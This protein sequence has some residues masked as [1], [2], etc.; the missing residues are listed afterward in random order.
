MN[1]PQ[2]QLQFDMPTPGERMSSGEFIALVASLMALS[3][4]SVDIML[5]ALPQM[6]DALALSH[7]NDRQAIIFIYVLGFAAGQLVFG[8]LSDLYGRRPTV[9]VGMV[10]FIAG[11]VYAALA[12]D[13]TSMLAARAVQGI[14]AAAA[15]VIAVALV[16]DRYVGRQMARAMSFAMAVFFSVPVLAPAIGQALLQFGSWRLIFDVLIATGL[17]LGLWCLRLPGAAARVAAAP[18]SF[19][20]ALCRA[21]G[22]PTTIAYAVAAGL[23]LGCVLA[24]VSSAQQVFVDVFGLGAM[25]PLAFAAIATMIVGAAIANGFLIERLGMRRLSHASLAAFVVAAAVLLAEVALGWASFEVFVATMMPLF[26]LFGFVAPNFNALAMEPQGDNAGM[27]ASVVGSVS[28]G[29]GA[30]AGGVVGHLFDGTLLPLAAGLLA[31]SLLAF[32]VV[33]WAEGVRGMFRSPAPSSVRPPMPQLPVVSKFA[34]ADVAMQLQAIVEAAAPDAQLS[35][36]SLRRARTPQTQVAHAARAPQANFGFLNPPVFRGSTVLF[37]TA[38]KFL[39]GDQAYTYGRKSTPTVRALEQAIA[40][41]EGGEACVLTGSGYQAVSTAIMAFVKSGDHVLMADTVYQPT[42]AFCD[43]TLAKF[44][45]STTYYDPLIGE[46]IGQ[47]V[48][49]N[50]RLIYAESPG[51]QTFEVQ[52]IPS[53]ARVAA[54]RNLWLLMDNTWASPLYFKPFEHGVDVSIQAATKYIVGHADAVLGAVTSNARAAKFIA[55]AKDQLGICPGSEETYLGLRG[56]RTL[57]T[58]LAQHHRSALQVA[59]WLEARPEVSRVLHPGLPS[60]PQHQIWKRDF[61]GASG[62][63]SVVLSPVR[64]EAVHALLDGLALFGIGLSWGG[65]ESLI[66]P[67]DAKGYRSA[68]PWEAEGPTLRIHIGLEDP[69]EL[70]SD[71]DAGFARLSAV[72]KTYER[73]TLSSSV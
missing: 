61:L 71:L 41:I 22:T 48:R 54:Q 47:L 38:E 21:F 73:R 2:R 12:P 1:A 6:S 42:R 53:I 4:L 24:Y 39:K 52:D 51:S 57:P 18:L 15:R 55:H 29:L 23:M 27:A 3:A 70:C 65:Y 69:E 46:A 59:S 72:A 67:F 64:Q 68:K 20:Q 35:A 14:G 33:T 37:P 31:L 9:I 8:R 44:G 17:A 34:G 7:A 62:L 66:I 36:S 16:R 32:M 56:L 26:L 50:T 25:F 60:H 10:T 28:T 58:R 49:P 13:P 45:V 43:D 30:L 5:P 63:F 40:E 11:S 19:A